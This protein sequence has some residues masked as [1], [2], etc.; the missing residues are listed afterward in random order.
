MI[1][2]VIFRLP[3]GTDR[4]AR[5]VAE[6]GAGTA[7]HCGNLTVT[8]P[9]NTVLQVR[10][11]YRYAEAQPGAWREAPPAAQPAAKPPARGSRPRR[12]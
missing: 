2:P 1:R 12:T 4:P 8:M 5:L 9:D 11:A 6:F 7:Y 3:D 10:E